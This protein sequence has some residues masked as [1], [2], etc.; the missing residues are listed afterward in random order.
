MATQY[1]TAAKRYGVTHPD[2]ICLWLADMDIAPPDCV[3]EQVMSVLTGACAGYQQ[4]SIASAVRGWYEKRG[5]P[6]SREASIVDIHSIIGGL[7]VALSTLIPDSSKVMVLTPTYA[8]LTESIKQTGHQCVA[9]PYPESPHDA[10]TDVLVPDASALLLCQPNNPTGQVLSDEQ[11][12]DVMRFCDRHDILILS[13]E[14]HADFFFTQTAPTPWS[15]LV[16]EAAQRVIQF[17]SPNKTFNLAAFP[18]ASYAVIPD[19]Q[20]ATSFRRAVDTTHMEAGNVSKVVLN[21][22]Y[23]HGEDWLRETRSVLKANRQWV[24]AYLQ[25]HQADDPEPCGEAGYFCWFNLARLLGVS[26]SQAWSAARDRG[27]LIADGKTFGRPGYARMT[28]A[29]PPERLQ[30]AFHRLR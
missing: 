16:P 20:C 29:T 18:G 1:A 12:S 5:Q 6:L 10:L 22:A 21:A 3:A 26:A 11:R 23:Q 27:V 8:P 15:H 7:S 24:T 28:L 19:A 13:D 9:V 25:E 2:P 14:A 4:L 17:A 30:D